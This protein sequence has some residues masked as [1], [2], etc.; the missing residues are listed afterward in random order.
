MM[1]LTALIGVV[2][3]GRAGVVLVGVTVVAAPQTH[4]F[5]SPRLTVCD[6]SIT[7]IHTHVAVKCRD[8]ASR[9]DLIG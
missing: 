5:D 1:G 9:T 7:S 8:T 6:R 4:F 2:C 3:A